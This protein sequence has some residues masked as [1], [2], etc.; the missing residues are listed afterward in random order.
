VAPQIEARV[1]ILGAEDVADVVPVLCETFSD[2]PVMRFVLDAGPRYEADLEKLVHFF[3]MARLLRDEV[4][5]GIRSRDGLSAAALVSYPG[6][7]LSPPEVADRRERLW[8][9]LGGAARARYETFGRA[10]DP[11]SVEAPHI[12]LNMIGVRVASQG[13]GLGRA[14]LEVVHGLSAEDS[15]STGITLVTERE[16]NV[17]LYEHFGYRHLGRVDIG[18]GLTTWGF[19]RPDQ[20]EAS[21]TMGRGASEA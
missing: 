3:V 15:G 21:A 7:R 17:P 5:L 12:H 9:E 4:V 1:E 11:L 13:Q 18:P 19:F 14:L 10:A 8:A 20:P 6:R 16:S 2:S